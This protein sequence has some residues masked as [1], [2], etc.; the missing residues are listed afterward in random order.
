MDYPTM[1]GGKMKAKNLTSAE[2]RNQ[3]VKKWSETA[4]ETLSIAIGIS[5]LVFVIYTICG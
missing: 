3:F 5:F 4:G 2:L 1:E